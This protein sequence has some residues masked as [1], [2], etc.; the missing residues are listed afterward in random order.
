MQNLDN[1]T[2]YIPWNLYWGK[3]C[4]CNRLK[5][6]WP[7]LAWIGNLKIK[8]KK[9][10]KGEWMQ[11]FQS[12]ISSTDMNANF[13]HDWLISR[14]LANAKQKSNPRSKQYRNYWDR[15]CCVIKIPI[16]RITSN[17]ARF[18]VSITSWYA[19]V[20]L[21]GT[22]FKGNMVWKDKPKRIMTILGAYTGD[23]M[24]ITPCIL[25][26]NATRKIL[27]YKSEDM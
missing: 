13:L 24:L 10:G 8:K 25:W 11:N 4:Y 2:T 3:H 12:N 20:G 17:I 27:A 26:V 7:L 16:Q 22:L 1:S 23:I 5:P 6:D 21:W 19:W 14:N 15:R 9:L 18:S